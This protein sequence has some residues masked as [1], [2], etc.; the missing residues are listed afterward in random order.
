MKR[1]DHIIR[2]LSGEL[3]PVESKQL[4]EALSSDSGLKEIFDQVSAAWELIGDQLKK[5]DEEAFLSRLKEV[6]E[7][8][9]P[10]HAAKGRRKPPGWFYLIP[11]AATLALV[12]AIFTG[13]RG[14][15]LPYE[16]FY[17]P[18]SDPVL[19]AVMQDTRGESGSAMALYSSGSYEAAYNV[20]SGL[21]DPDSL[22]RQV[23]L[24]HLLSAMELERAGEA[25]A[26]VNGTSPGQGEPLD[27]ALGWYT[28]L[29]Q[30]KAGD[31]GDALVTLDKLLMDPGLYKRDAHKLKKM[32]TK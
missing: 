19:Q 22:N 29:A 3:S 24:I 11:V 25:L 4:E 6:M 12:L 14:K 8:P 20:T 18:S 10:G 9:G 17:H 15:N 7:Q 32:L 5:K 16:R 26:L 2:Y 21:L 31:R 27:R 28:V 30:V 1:V 13:N 23:L